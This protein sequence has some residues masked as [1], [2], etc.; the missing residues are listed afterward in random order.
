L[1]R[2]EE[3]KVLDTLSSTNSLL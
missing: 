2:L 1:T 3:S